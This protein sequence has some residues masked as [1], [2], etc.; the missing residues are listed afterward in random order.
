MNKKITLSALFALLCLTSFGQLPMNTIE[1]KINKT[2]D[3]PVKEYVYHVSNAKLGAGGLL[4]FDFSELEDFE[5]DEMETELSMP[6]TISWMKEQLEGAKFTCT[7][8]PNALYDVSASDGLEDAEKIDREVIEIRVKTLE[9]LKRLAMFVLQLDDAHGKLNNIEFEDISSMH[10]TLFPEMMKMAKEKATIIGNAANK[11]V[12]DLLQVTE[13][14]DG[15]SLYGD[16][17][18]SYMDTMMKLSTELWKKETPTHKQVRVVVK[19][20]FELK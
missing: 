8:I 17:M 7:V 12:G 18:G 19:Y 16:E 20:V 11:K 6:K 1:V 9:E 14:S 5:E 4:D 10:S 2:V 15:L 3:V 13:G